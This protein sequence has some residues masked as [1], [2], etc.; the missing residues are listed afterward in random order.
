MNQHPLVQDFAKVRLA[1]FLKTSA[2]SLVVALLS[3]GLGFLADRFFGTQPVLTIVFFGVSYPVLQVYLF[4]SSRQKAK[5][6][7]ARKK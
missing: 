6:V 5:A 2:V 4:N 3:L 1:E 7:L